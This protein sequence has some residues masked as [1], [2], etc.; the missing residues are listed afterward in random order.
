MGQ[1]QPLQP[2]AGRDMISGLSPELRLMI[3]AH[4][5]AKDIANFKFSSR[6]M[7]DLVST[8]ET[9]ISEPRIENEMSRIA[10][11]LDFMNFDG[12]TF[13]DALRRYCKTY[14]SSYPET[15]FEHSIM[16]FIH[17]ISCGFALTIDQQRPNQYPNIVT[18]AGLVDFL[19]QTDY[20][21]QHRSFAP[22]LTKP[23][24]G[25]MEEVDAVMRE[26]LE[27]PS[28]LGSRWDRLI[29]KR[30][31]WMTPSM[32]LEMAVL[33]EE[34]EQEP[35]LK[36]EEWPQDAPV[37]QIAR[38]SARG[39]LYLPTELSKPLGLE[40]PLFW[41]ITKLNIALTSRSRCAVKAARGYMDEGKKEKSGLSWAAVLEETEVLFT[42][43]FKRK[44]PVNFG[45]LRWEGYLV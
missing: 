38:P 11:D 26:A 4:L 2:G 5:P 8:H 19:L 25:H 18:F 3:L 40:S 42:P 35:I 41:N 32:R 21:L 13:N 27:S 31:Q 29:D 39:L 44:R 37:R 12:L 7:K 36:K 17:T 16:H 23:Y 34:V 9:Y 45:P 22:T 33:L 28:A 43:S 20:W 30:C 15:G 6:A 14:R 24:L 1:S 10:K